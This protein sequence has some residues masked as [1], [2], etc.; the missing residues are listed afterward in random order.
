MPNN[1]TREKFFNIFIESFLVL[2]VLFLPLV[3]GSV[4]N[5][6]LFLIE[7]TSFLILLLTI[8]KQVF[9]GRIS[10]IKTPVFL[11]FLFILLVLFQLIR[12][13]DPV[14]SLISPNTSA[15]YKQ[16]SVNGLQAASI[17]IC[18]N[19]TLHYFFQFLSCLA[20]FFA[21]LCYLDSPDK[22][23]RLV[24]VIIISGF[25][26]SVYGILKRN[27]LATESEFST[28]TNYNHFSAYLEMI[29]FIAIGFSFADFSKTIRLL[30]IFFAAVMS[31]AIFLSASR[32]GRISFGLSFFF[33]FLILWFRKPPKKAVIPVAALILFIFLFVGLIGPGELLKRME[34]LANPLMAYQWRLDLLRDSFRAIQDFP[35]FGVGF[36]AFSEIIQKY[37]TSNWQG[38]YI[39]S[40]NEPVQLLAEMG[41]IGILPLILFFLIYMK[42][43]LS[44]WRQ[45]NSNFFIFMTA[46]FLTGLLSVLMH[47][48]FDF[49]FHVPANAIL[50]SIILALTYKTVYMKEHNNLLLV[51]KSEFTVPIFIKMPL[52][53]FFCLI[54]IL[55]GI[56]MARR[57]KAEATFES[58]KDTKLND[59][60]LD[61]FLKSVRLLKILDKAIALNSENGQ[62]FNKKGDILGDLATKEGLRGEIGV[63]G[64]YRDADQVLG[65]SEESY[66]RSII[67]N[68]TRADYHVRLGWLYGVTGRIGP[69]DL[70]LEKALKLDP[71]NRALKKYIEKNL[72]QER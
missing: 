44:M 72:N 21:I 61:G 4:T 40:H 37:K 12:L 53:V 13:P 5:L 55:G 11:L 24:G 65:L 69:K 27:P 71:T 9:E 46:G 18:S 17:S 64:V 49:I 35:Y 22:L 29:V 58:I 70:E 52:T 3:Y 14:L 30:T 59:S 45:R 68:P 31:A 63:S 48:F 67:L 23:K 10:I 47:S 57:Y 39:F 54:F 7:I 1:L 66:K 51:S 16:F 15:L 20:I 42:R 8:V 56:I 50:F 36:G 62:Y 6:P 33:F 19:L 32:A 28:F 41:V 60:G 43:I 25:L 26:Y 38:S 2:L 34:T